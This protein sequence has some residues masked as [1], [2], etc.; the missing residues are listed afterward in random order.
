M[1]INLINIVQFFD[2]NR[3]Q[4]PY[5]TADEILECLKKQ[6]PKKNQQIV[7][8]EYFNDKYVSF[9]IVGRETKKITYEYVGCICF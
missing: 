8:I 9:L 4:K 2:E 3:N 7:N 6:T 5:K 1:E